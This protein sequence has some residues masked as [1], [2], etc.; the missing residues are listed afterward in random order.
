VSIFPN[1]KRELPYFAHAPGSEMRKSTQDAQL[2][3]VVA[4]AKLE[5]KRHRSLG[6]F[7]RRRMASGVSA[8]SA[9][10]HVGVDNAGD[11]GV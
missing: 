11:R 3:A 1:P 8:K 6:P 2:F 4:R 10:E 7:L 5:Q 9:A